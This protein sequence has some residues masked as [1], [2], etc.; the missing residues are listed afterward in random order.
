MFGRVVDRESVPEFIGLVQ[1]EMAYKGTASV[2]A[3]V[4]QNQMDRLCA[5]IWLGDVL[6]H[7]CE[8]LAG[9][10]SVWAR[11]SGVQPVAPQR[12]RH[13]PSHSVRIRSHVWRVAAAVPGLRGASRGVGRR[14]F[15]PDRP[16][17]PADYKASGRLPEHLP[18][19]QG[20]PHSL[21][22]RTTFF[23]RRGLR[24]W[25]CSAMRMASRPMPV[26]I[27]R[28]LASA[29]NTRTVH[30]AYPGSGGPQARAPTF[31]CCVLSSAGC[32]PG[33][34]PSWTAASSPPSR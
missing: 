25:C 10:G 27:W 9:T 5:R 1:A 29:A 13:S 32:F 4:I 15:H 17:V 19:A 2:G 30:R 7:L 23:S 33:G 21:R 14:A 8:L 28:F 26:T 6:N 24:S 11:S 16:P 34:A 12:R 22:P 20:K 31:C 3:Q 18:S